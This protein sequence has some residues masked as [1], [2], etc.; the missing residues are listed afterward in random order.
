MTDNLSKVLPKLGKDFSVGKFSKGLASASKSV[1][2]LRNLNADKRKIVT[3]IF[4]K[5][6]RLGAAMT[7]G[8]NTGAVSRVKQEINSA[9]RHGKIES[10]EV[11][12]LKKI[13]DVYAVKKEAKE[14][15]KVPFRP[16]LDQ[17]AT[18]RTG[19]SSVSQLGRQVSSVKS[20]TD[21]RVGS[22]GSLM[23]PT[24]PTNV[25]SQPIV[26]RPTGL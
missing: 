5:S 8:L 10:K 18:P 20:V 17:E 23:N 1:S 12:G 24:R 26:R 2:G 21:R 19:V 9:L 4:G 22:I 6:T 11:S 3:E 15:K 14:V 16:Y 7:K 25:G 13:A